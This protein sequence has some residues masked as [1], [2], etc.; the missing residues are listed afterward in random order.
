MRPAPVPHPLPDRAIPAAGLPT[1]AAALLTAFLLAG[2]GGDQGDR[3][4]L[5]GSGSVE[6]MQVEDLPPHIQAQL[7]SG[8]A[9]FR[10]RDYD[11]ALTHFTQ[12][13]ELAPGLA[14]GWYGI[15]MTHSAMGNQEEANV[16]MMR[17]HRLAPEIPLEH[18]T[19]QAPPNPHPIQPPTSDDDGDGY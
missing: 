18:P 14:A 12:V 7:D 11:S 5:G 17:A 4:P 10:A 1:M 15:G 3:V 16:A 9:A 6:P 19:T 13:S 8:N 2:C